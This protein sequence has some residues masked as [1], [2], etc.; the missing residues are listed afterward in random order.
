MEE[1]VSKG[2][3]QA[4]LE[5][6]FGTKRSP[7]LCLSFVLV[8]TAGVG[9]GIS[10]GL[11]HLGIEAMWARYPLALLLAYVAFLGFLRVWVAYEQTR[12]DPQDP[13]LL[14][15][16]KSPP[17]PEP[18]TISTRNGSW[19][20]WLDIPDFDF[21]EGCLPALLIAAVAAL[22]GLFISAVGGAP[23]LIAELFI[24]IALAGLLYRRLRSAANEHWLGTAVRRT[25]PFVIGA[26][27]LVGLVGFCL[28]QLAPQ[29]DSMGP[30][31]KEMFG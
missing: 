4:A 10:R 21:G 6:Y 31:I 22:A 30:A 18:E 9:F 28:D 11:H 8:L 14:Q 26:A 1:E 7:R 2:R 15:S 17:Q 23:L 19:L 16:L 5:K 3:L 12:F 29:A 25:W 13:D 24:D 27:L 20:D